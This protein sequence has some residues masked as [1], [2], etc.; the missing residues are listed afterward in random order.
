MA[1]TNQVVVVTGTSSGFGKLIAES[2][3]RK[4]YTVFATMRGVEGKNAGAAN[5]FRE[6]AKAESLALN[7]AEMDVT[8]EASVDRC[9]AEVISKAGR[10]D[11]LVNNAG[12]GVLGLTETL[13]LTQSE[14]IFDTNFFGVMR[15]MRAALPQM[16]K[17]ASG[18]VVQISSGAGRIVL[19]GFGVYCATKAALEAM[20]EACSYELAPLGI[21]C[22]ILQPGAYPTE[23]FGKLETGAD[24]ARA[25][26]Y[27]TVRE[28]PERVNS[29]LTAST[30][31]PQEIADAVLNVIETPAGKRALRSR[32]GT[33]A[34]GVEVINETAAQV[35]KELLSAFGI[36]ELTQF[37]QGKS[38]TA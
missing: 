32:I 10:L 17:Q 7:V 27:G 14:A 15:T 4:G 13:T 20:T 11:I 31:N 6:L 9:I 23:I 36:A 1:S 34:G 38:A 30:A 29:I 16:R 12:Y 21:D 19:P 25:E 3:A 8:D 28:A 2:L 35:Q 33:G 5:R 22:V 18:L 37:R 24:A 26:G